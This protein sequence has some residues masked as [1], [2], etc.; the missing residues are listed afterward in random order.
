LSDVL[1]V[2]GDV[3][4]NWRRLDRVL[5]AIGKGPDV[6]GI[7][8]VGDLAN[9]GRGAEVK[10]NASYL[11]DIDKIFKRVRSLGVPMAYVPGNH[12]RPDLDQRGNI[13]GASCEMGELTVV[14]IGGAGPDRF[15]FPYEWDEDDIRG[16]D[17][18]QGDVILSHT[19]PARTTLDRIQRGKHVGSEAI[20]EIAF[21]WE[22]VL[23][24]GHIHEAAGVEQLGP[25]LCM[26]VGGLGHP[27][28][29]TQVGWVFGTQAVEYRN[30]DTGESVRAERT[31]EG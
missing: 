26:N 31:C 12:D 18:P 8:L 9:A 28:G 30:L 4:S 10:Q 7:L 3:H 16:R 1:A 15:G 5:N 20:R 24:C 27:Y 23:V 2:I 22:G 11:L 29:A 17:L 19:P 13:D 6:A 21:G 25:C 14:G